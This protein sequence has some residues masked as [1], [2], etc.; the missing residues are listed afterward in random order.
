MNSVMRI[1]MRRGDHSS[2]DRTLSPAS[3]LAVA[4]GH[5]EK[6]SP[7][8]PLRD[9][10]FGDYSCGGLRRWNPTVTW[11][12]VLLFRY[13]PNDGCR[14]RPYSFGS[15]RCEPYVFRASEELAIVER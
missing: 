8:R 9:D 13:F 14:A 7:I 3:G 5:L 2:T 11:Y 12:K 10:G 4:D 6:K 15:A 1:A